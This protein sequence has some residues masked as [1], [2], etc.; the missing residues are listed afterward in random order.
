VAI[1]VGAGVLTP[2]ATVS[3]SALGTAGTLTTV[4]AAGFVRPP[5]PPAGTPSPGRYTGLGFDACTAPSEQ[6][7]KAWKASPYRAVGIYIGGVNR[8]C[9]QP[10][11]TASWVRN[12]QAAG[13]HLMPLYVGPQAPCTQLKMRAVID[14]ARAAAQG[15]AAAD[16]AAAQARALGLARES[17]LIYDMESYP[18]ADAG[19]R[20]AVL[21][22][23]GAY[24][25]RLHEL[26]YLSG[27]YSSMG[28]GIAHQVSVY[29]E[30]AYPRPDYVDFARWDGV[31]TVQDKG[32]TAGEWLPKRRM[33]QFR[34]G[35]LETHGGVTI[36][37]D[38]DYLDVAPIPGTRFGD[39]DRNGWADVLARNSAGGLY[40]Y[41]GTGSGHG[42]RAYLGGGWKAMDQVTRLGDFNR[43]GFE[44]V[45]ALERGTGVLWLYRGTA[46]GLSARVRLAKGWKNMRELTAVGDFNRDGR[47]DL[48]AVSKTNGILY[49]YPGKG[50]GLGPAKVLGRGWKARNEL[51]GVGDFNRDGHADLIARD[52]STGSL[53]LYPGR[54]ATLRPRVLLARG[55]QG[56]RNVTGV[57]DFDRDGFVDLVA[58]GRWNGLLYLY[59]GRGRA[60]AP[61]VRIGTAW[62]GIKDLL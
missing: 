40:L 34:G 62:G 3:A 11:L 32:L 16:D 41:P 9:R 7:M 53:Y 21:K 36:N 48:V 60:L 6:A 26:S 28:S 57:G 33:K 5:Q 39:L 42:A 22:F 52:Q 38:S 18:A 4:R 2:L 54:G 20:S 50:N 14:P 55:F 56:L 45:I 30:G 35:H 47:P 49:L 43:D 23:M 44:D 17:V 13:W 12:Q 19:C 58:I 31:A 10:N 51:A 27:Y 24:T 15:R 8:G 25:V 29:Q 61:R 37:I 1:V 46:T 59:P